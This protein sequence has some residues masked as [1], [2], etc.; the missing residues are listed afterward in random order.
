[1]K[2]ALIPPISRLDDCKLTDYHLVLPQ[3]F[4]NYP[5]YRAFYTELAID[6]DNYIILDNGAAEGYTCTYEEL[7]RCALTLDADEVV[8]PDAI[9][10]PEASEMLLQGFLEFLT[11]WGYEPGTFKFMAVAQGDTW[12]NFR[13]YVHRVLMDDMNQPMVDTIGLPRHMLRT[14]KDHR[15]RIK[16]ATEIYDVY[17]SDAPAIHFLGASPLWTQELE[18]AVEE[19]PFVRGMDTSM[20]YVYGWYGQRIP[21][22]QMI[23]RPNRYFELPAVASVIDPAAIDLNVK[24]MLNW[25][26]RGIVG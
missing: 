23:D 21:T 20:P 16:L 22:S 18:Y 25:T 2:L 5:R 4:F 19:V 17:G 1:M 3:L 12:E 11:R 14:C 7:M 26:R 6:L 13:E 8:I 9:K 15:A 10:Q 24:T